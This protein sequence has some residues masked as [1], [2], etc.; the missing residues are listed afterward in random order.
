M[1]WICAVSQPRKL[2][3]IDKYRLAEEFL[4]EPVQR[5]SG[6]NELNRLLRYVQIQDER[7]QV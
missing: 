6:L 2:V 1:S 7:I 5:F 4:S 3:L